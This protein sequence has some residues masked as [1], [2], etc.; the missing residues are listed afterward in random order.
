MTE[1][2]VSYNRQIRVQDL[3][4]YWEFVELELRFL[5]AEREASARHV[6]WS[7]AG[8]LS[9]KLQRSFS[10]LVSMLDAFRL[11]LAG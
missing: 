4:E 6:A 7:Q 10:E 1:A 8:A 11:A 3:P 5:I 9:Q 2:T